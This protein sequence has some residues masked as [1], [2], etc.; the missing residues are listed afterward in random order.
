MN[1]ILSLF[2][3]LILFEV[4]SYKCVVSTAF[5]YKGS[6]NLYIYL[7]AKI[8][9]FAVKMFIKQNFLEIQLLTLTIL[10]ARLK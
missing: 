10:F 7:L 9:F 5:F 8:N 3:Y 6:I 4:K 1:F 2:I